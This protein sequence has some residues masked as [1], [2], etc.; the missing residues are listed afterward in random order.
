MSRASWSFLDYLFPNSI[1]I[2]M[3]FATDGAV[4]IS[5]DPPPN[6]AVWF[7]PTSVVELHQTGNF[8]G[9]S[10]QYRLSYSAAA[11][12]YILNAKEQGFKKLMQLQ[13]YENDKY[14]L[15][16][17]DRSWSIQT[18]FFLN[19]IESKFVSCV[20]FW[21]LVFLHL[22]EIVFIPEFF[23]FIRKQGTSVLY[24]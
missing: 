5:I 4:R 12:I 19:Y 18:H 21:I 16:S 22:S 24:P 15:F 20:F 9:R 23:I 13:M 7:E 10:T 3:L 17:L 1:L 14:L 6:V 8:V 2:S 11:Y